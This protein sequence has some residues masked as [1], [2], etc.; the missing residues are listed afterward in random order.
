LP[1]GYLSVLIFV[2]IEWLTQFFQVPILYQFVDF[3]QGA[4]HGTFKERNWF[5]AFAF[6]VTYLLYLKNKSER[7]SQLSFF[8]IA[9]LVTFLTGSKTVLIV[10]GAAVVLNTPGRFL[11]KLALVLVGGV[12]YFAWFSSELSGELLDV[13]LEEERG[14]AF[15]EG[16][17]L[18]SRNL[19]GY[20]LGFVEYYFA[21]LPFEVKGLGEGTNSLFCTPLDLW[22]IA[23]PAGLA[24]WAVFFSGF[25]TRAVLLL[26]PV[27]LWSLLNPLHQSEI[28]YFFCG[29]LISWRSLPVMDTS[30]ATVFANSR[31]P[32]GAARQ[33]SGRGP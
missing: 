13:R 7:R 25:G 15:A 2:I 6:F 30:R 31:L 20:G 5:A 12:F 32:F 26:A 17:N 28:V 21:S 27:A 10:C 22:V 18:V 4:I 3:S 23:G 24:F 1:Y 14:L 11:L 29:V 8:G 16:I 19:I 33:D 9:L